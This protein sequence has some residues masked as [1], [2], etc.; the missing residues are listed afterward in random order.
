MEFIT[1]LTKCTKHNTLNHSAAAFPI[2]IWAMQELRKK[3]QKEQ[4]N[5]ICK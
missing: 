5:N 2:I 3:Q 1:W 4:I